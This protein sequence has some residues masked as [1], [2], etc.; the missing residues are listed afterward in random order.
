MRRAKKL[1]NLQI[2]ISHSYVH[3]PYTSKWPMQY[4]A[5]CK[6]NAKTPNSSDTTEFEQFAPAQILNILINVSP[7]YRHGKGIKLHV[8]VAPSFQMYPS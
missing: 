3:H 2:G 7:V 4:N 5:E 8:Q 6:N 1:I